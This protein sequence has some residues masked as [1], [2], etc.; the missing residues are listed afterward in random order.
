MTTYTQRELELIAETTTRLNSGERVDD[1]ITYLKEAGLDM[2]DS[3]LVLTET[4]LISAAEAKHAVFRHP[5]WVVERTA[6]VEL[7]RVLIEAI[8]E[9]PEDGPYVR[10][11]AG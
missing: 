2:T 3:M 11:L 8:D 9:H 10:D 7:H 5:A 4:K 1:T 6:A